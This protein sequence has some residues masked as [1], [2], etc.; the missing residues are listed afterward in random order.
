M[1]GF[2]I[3]LQAGRDW[4]SLGRTKTGMARRLRD[5]PPQAHE[6]KVSGDRR[7]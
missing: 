7:V 5:N 1:R 4:L 6:L 2:S 3:A